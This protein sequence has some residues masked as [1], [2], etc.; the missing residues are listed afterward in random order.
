MVTFVI[1]GVVAA[2]HSTQV[3]EHIYRTGLNYHFKSPVVA[4]Y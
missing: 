3:R 1:A 2:T 4:K